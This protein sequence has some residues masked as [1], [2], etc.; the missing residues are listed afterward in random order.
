MSPPLYE[1]GLNMRAFYVVFFLF[2][3]ALDHV[4]GGDYPELWYGARVGPG[5]FP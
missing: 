5:C 2:L 4:Q 3:Q 1:V